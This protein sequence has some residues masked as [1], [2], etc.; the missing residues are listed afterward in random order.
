MQTSASQNFPQNA[1]YMRAAS[2]DDHI[3]SLHQRIQD[4]E[5]QLSGLANALSE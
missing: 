1:P 3:S 5:E 4:L 2:N